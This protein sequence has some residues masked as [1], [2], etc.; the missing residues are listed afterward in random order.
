M[1]AEAQIERYMDAVK[2]RLSNVTSG[3]RAEIVDEISA[4]IHDSLRKLGASVESVLAK[5]GP[6]EKL[7]VKYR[8]ARLLARASESYMPPVLM[9]AL[10]RSGFLGVLAFMVGLVG[11]WLSGGLIA[12]GAVLVILSQVH[13]LTANG[14][15]AAAVLRMIGVGVLI[16]VLTTV[17]LHFVVGVFRRRQPTLE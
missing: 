4:R 14:S 10:A 7:A 1:T 2:A 12:F 5:M 13:P 16:L 6:P 9:H 8:D 3:E 11:Y 17:A 15:A